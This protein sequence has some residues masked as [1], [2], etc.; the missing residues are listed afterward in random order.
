MFEFF[1]FTAEV[2]GIECCLVSNIVQNIFS[3]QNKEKF[4]TI[5]GWVNDDRI[6]VFLAELSLEVH[7]K[8][9]LYFSIIEIGWHIKYF[10]Y[11]HW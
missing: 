10:Q 5:R 7:T 2:N 8:P 4:E 1:V 6:F 3:S 9:H 11:K